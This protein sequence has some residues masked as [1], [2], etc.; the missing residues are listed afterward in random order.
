MCRGFVLPGLGVRGACAPVGTIVQ[1]AGV[2]LAF[3]AVGVGAV[4]VVVVGV[5]AFACRFGA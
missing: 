5:G 4:G 3:G 2:A 1:G